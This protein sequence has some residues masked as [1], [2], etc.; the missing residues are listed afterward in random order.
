LYSINSKGLKPR[1]PSFY[2]HPVGYRQTD[3]QTDISDYKI[4]LA[5]LHRALVRYT[6]SSKIQTSA[7]FIN[8]NADIRYTATT[9]TA[10]HMTDTLRS[11]EESAGP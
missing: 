5:V 7:I 11:S 4:L 8:I 3:G 9:A 10:T 1:K 2:I 6:L